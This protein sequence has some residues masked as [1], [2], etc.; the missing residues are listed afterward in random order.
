MGDKFI[1]RDKIDCAPQFRTSGRETTHRVLSERGV[2]GEFGASKGVIYR[3]VRR[4]LSGSSDPGTPSFCEIARVPVVETK[5]SVR[6][7]A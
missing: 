7:E 6:K 4:A 5:E 3:S 2:G 1:I